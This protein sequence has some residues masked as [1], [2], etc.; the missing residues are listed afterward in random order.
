MARLTADAAGLRA[1]GILS[2]YVAEINVSAIDDGR[3]G[4]GQNDPQRVLLPRCDR[5]RSVLDSARRPIVGGGLWRTGD[6]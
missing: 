3:E 6:G 4:T 1:A 5:L 2:G